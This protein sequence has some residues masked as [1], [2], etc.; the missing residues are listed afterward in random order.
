MLGKYNNLSRYS[1]DRLNLKLTFYYH[2]EF[3]EEVGLFVQYYH[4]AD[5]YNVY[6]NHRIDVIRFGIMTDKLNF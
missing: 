2:P 5:Y 3:L 6:F 4:G 1:F